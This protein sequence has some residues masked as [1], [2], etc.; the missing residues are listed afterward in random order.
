MCFIKETEVIVI[1]NITELASSKSKVYQC[2]MCDLRVKVNS[3]LCVQ[4]GKLIHSRWAGVKVEITLKFS[5]MFAFRKC[6]GNTE[7]SVE[8]EEI[9]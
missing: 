3:V 7:E 9:I 5:R 8:Q 2:W 6:Q 1:R 4:C